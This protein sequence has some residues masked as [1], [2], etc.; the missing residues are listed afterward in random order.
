MPEFPSAQPKLR[1]EDRDEPAYRALSVANYVTQVWSAWLATD[2]ERV[3]RTTNPRTGKTPWI[4]PE[5]LGSPVPA[6][7]PSKFGQLVL[8]EPVSKCSTT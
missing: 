6:A 8:P 3:R 7:F 5:A 2:D 4:M 1:V